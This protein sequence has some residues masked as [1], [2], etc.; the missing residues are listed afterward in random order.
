M[1][2]FYISCL[3]NLRWQVVIIHYLLLGNTIICSA[4]LWCYSAIKSGHVIAW[5]MI[6]TVEAEVSNGAGTDA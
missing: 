1:L 5:R 4:Y 3:L 2:L 6:M